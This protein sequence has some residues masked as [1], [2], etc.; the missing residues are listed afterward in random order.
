MPLCTI[1]YC[2]YCVQ[3][4]AC[5]SPKPMWTALNPDN[6]RANKPSAFG[7]GAVLRRCCLTWQVDC[8]WLAKLRRPPLCVTNCLG[9]RTSTVDKLSPC[10]KCGKTR[11]CGSLMRE[12]GPDSEAQQLS[13]TSVTST[14]Y[15]E[16]CSTSKA[17]AMMV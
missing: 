4:H 6:V 13:C 17:I 2:R 12:D 1:M 11:K 14:L 7:K 8:K 15:N 16:T 9:R 5:T 3:S 10:G